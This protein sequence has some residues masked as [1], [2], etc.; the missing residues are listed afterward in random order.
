MYRKGFSTFQ[1]I[2]YERNLGSSDVSSITSQGIFIGP[3]FSAGLH[4]NFIFLTIFLILAGD[5]KTTAYDSHRI[6]DLFCIQTKCEFFKPHIYYTISIVCTV[7][8]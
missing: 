6:Y 1:D 7:I 8:H 2:I 5:S 4:R 3:R